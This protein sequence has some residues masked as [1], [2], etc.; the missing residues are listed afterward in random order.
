MTHLITNVHTTLRPPPP[1]YKAAFGRPGEA[2]G[3]WDTA[4]RAT[5]GRF[6]RQREQPRL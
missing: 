2:G 1:T 6:L 4:H 5:G 3:K